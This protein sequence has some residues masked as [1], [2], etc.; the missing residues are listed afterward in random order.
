MQTDYTCSAKHIDLEYDSNSCGQD[1]EI[2]KC[3]QCFA[4][5]KRDY[6]IILKN[7]DQK[8]FI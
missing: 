6:S 7:E 8:K 1:P 5:E 2:I 4:F 3:R